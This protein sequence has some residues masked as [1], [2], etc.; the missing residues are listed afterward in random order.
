MISVIKYKVKTE[1][2]EK[3][4]TVELSSLNNSTTMRGSIQNEVPKS[5]K[6]EK[7]NDHRGSLASSSPPAN[8]IE[9]IHL[10]TSKTAP[11]FMVDIPHP[12]IKLP[13][14]IMKALLISHRKDIF[15]EYD[16]TTRQQSIIITQVLPDASAVF[17][18]REA[19]HFGERYIFDYIMYIGYQSP[20]AVIDPLQYAIGLVRGTPNSWIFNIGNPIVKNRTKGEL[21]GFPEYACQNQVIKKKGTRGRFQ[22]DLMRWEF[23][24]DLGIEGPLSKFVWTGTRKNRK[25]VELEL[26]ERQ[27]S[28]R[29]L[30]VWRSIQNQDPYRG[31]LWLRKNYIECRQDAS[32][33]NVERRW[34]VAVW[35]T[36]RVLLE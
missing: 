8:Q 36:W 10:S 19:L 6:N 2:T 33:E 22:G 25:L 23:K 34:A 17:C 28:K 27:A 29:V 11:A 4:K 13:P 3:Q 21:L 32:L 30:A 7:K 18:I 14:S 12:E 35:L 26:R 16:T 31:R 5:G 15:D 9:P 20:P 1:P 24:A